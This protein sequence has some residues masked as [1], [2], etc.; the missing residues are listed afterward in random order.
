LPGV[1]IQRGGEK[2]LSNEQIKRKTLPTYTN[3]SREAGG[4][5]LCTPKIC[6]ATE[7]IPNRVDRIK[8]LGNAII[9]RI[10]EIIGKEIMNSEGLYDGKKIKK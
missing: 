6:G 7:R 3:S 10:A 8:S 9:P 5:N 1:R 4:W 2:K